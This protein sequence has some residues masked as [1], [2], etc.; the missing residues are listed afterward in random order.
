MSHRRFV[1]RPFCAYS[2]FFASSSTLSSFRCLYTSPQSL[3]CL[4]RNRGEKKMMMM[5]SILW[6]AM[7]AEPPFMLKIEWDIFHL[8]YLL[9]HYM[10]LGAEEHAC[11]P[12][13][14]SYSQISAWM[15]ATPMTAADI[16]LACGITT[17]SLLM[18]LAQLVF[19]IFVHFMRHKNVAHLASMW[20]WIQ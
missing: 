19:T 16:D 8:L 9:L 7:M 15:T 10:L 5:M 18:V 12:L 14:N 4:C 17:S 11:A 13:P 1:V 2:H 6:R 3:W 20:C